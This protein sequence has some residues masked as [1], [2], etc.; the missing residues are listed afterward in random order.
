M[1]KYWILTKESTSCSFSTEATQR[2]YR[3]HRGQRG[4]NAKPLFQ[5]GYRGSILFLLMHMSCMIVHQHKKN[6]ASVTSLKKGIVFSPLWNLCV[7]SVEKRH[8]VHYSMKICFY[9]H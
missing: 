9:F 5:R 2:H 4:E 6:S 8:C 3:G 7:A 1:E